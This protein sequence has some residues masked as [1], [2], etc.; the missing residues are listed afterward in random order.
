MKEN[1]NESKTPAE[2]AKEGLALAE[3]NLPER[4]D[5]CGS[6]TRSLVRM[7]QQTTPPSAKPCWI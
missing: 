2:L 4:G 1:A 3:H 6:Y 7:P 5:F